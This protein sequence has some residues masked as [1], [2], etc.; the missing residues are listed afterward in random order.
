MEETRKRQRIETKLNSKKCYVKTSDQKKNAVVFDVTSATNNG[1]IYQINLS[2]T[3][4]GVNFE[5][6]CGDQWN[7]NPKRNNCKHIGSMLATL[8]RT[9]VQNHITTKDDINMDDL[10]D[11]FKT[12]LQ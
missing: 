8:I 9:Y 3:L 7:I 11:K 4:Q 5:C 10:L 1:T 2:N 6:S 12:I